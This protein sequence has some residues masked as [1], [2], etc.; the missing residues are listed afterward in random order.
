[1]SSILRFKNENNEWVQIT[2][3][4]MI[5]SKEN[6]TLLIETEEYYSQFKLGLARYSSKYDNATVYEFQIISGA[7]KK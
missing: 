6:K 7:F 3:I 1:M 5:D 2:S 4:S